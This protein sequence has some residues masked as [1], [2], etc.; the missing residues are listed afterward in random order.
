MVQLENSSFKGGDKM[1]NFI[2]EIETILMIVPPTILL[3]SGALMAHLENCRN[4]RE[5][6]DEH[7]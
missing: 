7:E 2:R 1:M 3:A 4:E 6:V 5:E